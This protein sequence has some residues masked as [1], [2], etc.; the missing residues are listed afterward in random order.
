MPLFIGGVNY[1]SWLERGS[2]SHANALT[3]QPDILD[4]NLNPRNAE[5][6]R[7]PKPPEGAEVL[8]T[9]PDDT[10]LF[11][12]V[13]L[14]APEA[15]VGFKEMG[16]SCSCGDWRHRA[17]RKALNVREVNIKPGK[18]LAQMFATY[19]PEFDTS[20]IDQTGGE[21][22]AAIRFSGNDRLT[23]AMDRLAR[24]TGYVWDITPEKVVI[25]REPSSVPAPISLLDGSRNFHELSAHIDRSQLRNRVKVIGAM[26]QKAAS[27][28]DTFDGDGSTTRFPLTRTPFSDQPYVVFT[29]DF[30][31]L[32]S[33][34]WAITSPDNPS[35]PAGHPSTA[36][37]FV[38]SI[39]VGAEMSESG[40]LQILGGTGVWGEARMD[41]FDPI[42]RGDGGRRFEV[43]VL[44]L[45]TVG[46]GRFGLWDPNALGTLAGE[47]WSFFFD[48]GT[49]KP[50]VGGVA[51]TALE[52]VTYVADDQVRCRII[53]GE[54]EGAA[55][56]V[57]PD[58][59]TGFPLTS[60]VKLYETTTG[61]L[62]NLAFS[63]LSLDFNGRADRARVFNRLLD[64]RLVVDGLELVIGRLHMDEDAGVDALVGFDPPVVAF[65]GDSTPAV[66]TGNVLFTYHEGIPVRSVQQDNDSIAAVAA[67]EG[68]DGIYEKVI[69][70]ETITRTSIARA[71]A[72]QDLEEGANPAVTLT[73]KT[74]ENG[75]RAGQLLT[76]DL[77]EEGTGR[78]LSGTFLIQQVATRSLGSGNYEYTVTAGSR[79]KGLQDYILELLK[80]GKAPEEADDENALLEEMTYA[81]DEV[82]WADTFTAE[83][84]PMP[85]YVYGINLWLEDGSGFLALED[86]A[87]LSINDDDAPALYGQSTYG[88]P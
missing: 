73:F 16:Y 82:G 41:S 21:A 12:G 6:T 59:V 37:F 30:G 5:G 45:D 8:Y 74:R 35:P 13:L 46:Q 79:L 52:T 69:Q 88:G 83:E 80:R 57:N 26:Q 36:G 28:T 84:G 50:S 10:L 19:A 22:I 61:T 48:A 56:W 33:T 17:D 67:L 54:E 42:G 64:A 15:P 24:R 32:D 51:Q 14:E 66:G 34:K 49:I 2:L 78:D 31:S 18:L 11:G 72:R 4:F 1:D 76:V 29:D 44:P 55:L 9:L 87:Q 43:D 77:T 25:W 53:P 60:W 20:G 85:P 40:F 70:D 7:C 68:N 47:A 3:S 71:V 38:T 65:F 39:Q 63:L 81:N 58:G 27:T 62:E 23:D 86:G 75:L